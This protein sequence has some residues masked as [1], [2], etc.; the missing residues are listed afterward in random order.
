MS[1]LHNF[2]VTSRH[3]LQSF[4]PKI[5][6]QRI[7]GARFF[8][9]NSTPRPSPETSAQTFGVLLDIDGVL[10]RG[11][12]PIPGAKEALGLLQKSDVPTVFLTNGGLEMEKELAEHL[13]DRIGFEVSY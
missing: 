5:S 8:C 10:V 3:F 13:S 7:F 2:Y 4:A 1:R 9:E 6:V 12:N 11:R